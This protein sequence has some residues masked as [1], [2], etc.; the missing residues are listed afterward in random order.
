MIQNVRTKRTIQGWVGKVG[1]ADS[2]HDTGAVGRCHSSHGSR[3]GRSSR[4]IELRRREDSL[5]RRGRVAV[6]DGSI[7]TGACRFNVSTSQC[8]DLLKEKLT[9]VADDRRSIVDKSSLNSRDA[10]GGGGDG[11]NGRVGGRFAL[12]L[13][14]SKTAQ[15]G[16]QERRVHDGDE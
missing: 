12:S 6:L 9:G 7:S 15:G 3:D 14:E 13:D 16:D 11:R 5:E 1:Q 4:G 8:R 2:E 10:N